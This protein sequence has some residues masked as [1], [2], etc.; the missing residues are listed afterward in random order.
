MDTKLKNRHKLV[1][2]I[3]FLTILIPS[4]VMVEQYGNIYYDMSQSEE[5]TEKE[6]Q[7]SGEF[8]EKFVDICYILY[9]TETSA[10]R[11]NQYA[12]ENEDLIGT[13][14]SGYEEEEYET[15]V[16]LLD[17]RVVDENRKVVAKTMASSDSSYP[18]EQNM[19]DY[20]IGMVIAFDENGQPSAAILEGKFKQAQST[21]LNKVMNNFSDFSPL[22]PWLESE[23]GDLKTP[24]NRTYYLA[25]REENVQEYLQFMSGVSAQMFVPGWFYQWMLLLMTAVAAAAILLPFCKSFHTGE[26]KIFRVPIEIPLIALLAAFLIIEDRVQ[27]LR[28]DAYG[29]DFL[30]WAA[31]FAVVYWSAAC[32]RRIFTA[33]RKNMKECTLIVPAAGYVKKAGK[34]VFRKCREGMEYLYHSFDNLD[35]SEKNNKT[36]LKLVLINFVILLFVTCMW[37]VGIPALILY[38]VILF[39]VLR[40]YFNDL[41]NKYALLLKATNQM[42]Q[43]KLDVEID[44]DLGV[45]NPF[46]TEIAKIQDGYQKAV[47]KEVKSQ[48]MKTE[49]ITNVSHDLKTPLTAIITYVNLL[50][51]EKD[52]D[53]RRDYIGVLE[54]KSLRLKALIED[55]FEI[56]K[57][58]SKNVTLHLVDVDVVNLFKQVRLELSEKFETAELEFRCTYPEEKAVA[59]L[60]SQKTYRVFENL[61]VNVVKYAMPKTRVYVKIEKKNSEIMLQIMNISASEL[62][63]ND[64]EITER[65]VRGDAARNTEGSGLGLAIAKSFTELQK[66]R[67]KIETEGDL[68][69]AEVVFEA[70]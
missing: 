65:F 42:A 57:A 15:F 24:K 11:N 47:E 39:Y 35:F 43:G 44:E 40:K 9:G 1:V 30:L 56:S 7:M 10:G 5:M 17:Y 14:L 2:V 58:S 28:G 45:F 18:T 23:E 48:R 33:G 69:K 32:V 20:A 51:E 41:K 22:A 31:V 25:M 19:S 54:K 52:E 26:E 61:L 62:T 38:S 60:D 8:L 46:K 66:G 68:F 63:F 53:K 21:Q 36:I 49:L 6:G 29:I 34:F 13:Y 27:S 16:S 50:K 70:I 12:Q 55:L 67:F 3:I 59:K 4:F 37:F 64:D